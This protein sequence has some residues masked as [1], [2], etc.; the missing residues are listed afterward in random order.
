MPVYPGALTRGDYA[1]KPPAKGLVWHWRPRP[2]ARYARSSLSYHIVS[3]REVQRDSASLARSHD[4]VV[5][6]Q[7]GHLSMVGRFFMTH[8]NDCL[9]SG[10]GAG[11]RSNR[12][13]ISA[14]PSARSL[15]FKR[16]FAMSRKLETCRSPGL[17]L[18]R[19]LRRRRG[20]D[21][22]QG[23]VESS[24]SEQSRKLPNHT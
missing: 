5:S 2:T 7:P 18:Q 13:M 12:S 1:Q 21:P 19:T 22:C 20:N 24:Y 9:E 16:Y 23:K 11:Q 6:W 14:G 4:P 10:R 15:G 17:V 8:P 3:S